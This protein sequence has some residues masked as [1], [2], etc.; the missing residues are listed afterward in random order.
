M[1]ASIREKWNALSRL[2]FKPG[3]KY[4]TELY[5]V[6]LLIVLF[7]V[8]VNFNSIRSV[9][10]LR[11]V[12]EDQ[13]YTDLFKTAR[14]AQNY[15]GDRPMLLSAT[16][17]WGNY[18]SA[19]FADSI[20][21]IEIP[22]SSIGLV[23]S[24][25]GRLSS[26]QVGRL[27]D[28]DP[29]SIEPSYRGLHPGYVVWYPF[30][31]NDGRGFLM[32]V[33]KRT[34]KFGVVAN[35]ARF[36]TFFQVSG[37]LAVLVLGYLYLR[38]TLKPYRKMKKAATRVGTPTRAE[39]V[40]VDEIVATFQEMI[41]EMKAREQALQ[42]LYQKTQKRA[43]RLE[44]F[45]EYILAGMTSGLISC[46]REGAVTHFNHAVQELLDMS[47]KQ[48]IGK[49]YSEVLQPTPQLRELVKDTL[50]AG[51]NSSRYE[52]ELEKSDRKVISL[53]VSTTLITD[54]RGRK[55][56]VTIIMSDLT[57]IKRLQREIAY[58]E[59]MAAL[60]ETAAG[61]AHELRNSMT[62]IVGYGKLMTKYA[63]ENP[64][65]RH[66]AESIASEC[67]AT[68][69]MLTRFL[70]FAQP[71]SFS[72]EAVDLAETIHSIVN[73]LSEKAK[74]HRVVVRFINHDRSTVAWADQLAVR[75]TI[76]N[77]IVNAIEASP[78]GGIVEVEACDDEER[79]AVSVSVS[80]N[81][82]GIPE[83][84]REKV[85][86]PFF[87]TKEDGTGLGLCTVRKLATGMHGHI[88]LSSFGESPFTVRLLL[89]YP[90]NRR[91]P[92]ITDDAR[93]TATS[94]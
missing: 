31:T 53:G 34:D 35:I 44:Q 25:A 93:T 66:A 1:R 42:A 50:E 27:D 84:L 47:E 30:E 70:A 67:S 12:F 7:L 33:Y 94:R 92:D 20:E 69:E 11:G 81:G 4:E 87:T 36:N 26:E 28:G 63:E 89:P 54:E 45:N 10:Q 46:D 39:D 43:A 73:G 82:P 72:F 41:D 29:L 16:S 64:R 18:T 15:L 79:Q 76:S 52:L 5:S 2:F 49:H 90:L 24:I 37:L 3:M 40:S 57:K 51:V 13:I 62:A 65:I 56:G 80:D 23:P 9:S 61:L 55:V 21:V 60:G 74:E 75:Q 59:K 77:L 32:R 83:E 14:E 19:G 68:E 71:T 22:G 58:K 8:L 88:E 38:T 17:D 85:F 6:L 78:Q 48:A 86:S 91:E